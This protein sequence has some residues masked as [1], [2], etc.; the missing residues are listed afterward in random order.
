MNVVKKKSLELALAEITQKPNVIIIYTDDQGALD[1]GCY[2][3]RDI[4]TPN[5]DRLATEGLHV[6]M[7][8]LLAPCLAQHYWLD[9]FLFAMAL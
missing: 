7:E 1:A 3:A 5:I 2:G 6:S 4:L 9:S 8:R